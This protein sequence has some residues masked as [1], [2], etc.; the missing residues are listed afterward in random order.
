[1]SGN[2]LE[3]R[4]VAATRHLQRDPAVCALDAALALALTDHNANL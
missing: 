2:Y 3:A 4:Y 1:M